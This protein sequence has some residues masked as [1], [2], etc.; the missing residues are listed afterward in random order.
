MLMCKVPLGGV[1]LHVYAVSCVHFPMCIEYRPRSSHLTGSSLR[2]RC[3][4]EVLNHR[5]KIH[6]RDG[7]CFLYVLK[8]EFDLVEDFLENSYRMRKH[9]YQDEIKK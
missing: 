7:V 3:L 6:R 4:L 1:V 8:C 9:R 2:E 5:E